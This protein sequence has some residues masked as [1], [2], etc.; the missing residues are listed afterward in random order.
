MSN[1]SLPNEQKQQMKPFNL[2][3]ALAGKPV[4]TRDGKNVKQIV[5]FP[6]ADEGYRIAALIEGDG[7]PLVFFVEGNNNRTIETKEDL[8]MKSEKVIKWVNLYRNINGQIVTGGLT[9]DSAKTAI[10]HAG[11]A[12]HQHIGAYP[13]EI[14]L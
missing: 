11:R 8:F 6:S 1:I 2:Q 10:Q 12:L 13:T 7:I 4:V 3:E 9:Y 5:H 14:E